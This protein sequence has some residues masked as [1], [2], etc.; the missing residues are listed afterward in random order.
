[1]K[2]QLQLTLS[3]ISNHSG[4]CKCWPVVGGWQVLRPTLV[5]AVFQN[6]VSDK[7]SQVIDSEQVT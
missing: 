5:C 3:G 4:R 7:I 1:M 2:H 6:S